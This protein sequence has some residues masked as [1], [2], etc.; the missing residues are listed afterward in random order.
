MAF[1]AQIVD[2]RTG[3]ALTP[4]TQIHADVPALVGEAGIA[5]AQFGPTQKEQVTG[6]LVAVFQGWLGIGP[7]V[8]GTFSSFGR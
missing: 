4:P 8:R 7:D 3:A 1:D 5:A 2:A 6:H